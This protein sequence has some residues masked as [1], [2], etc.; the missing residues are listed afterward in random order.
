MAGPTIR[1]LGWAIP[2]N[3]K[4]EPRSFK[5][6]VLGTIACLTG[7]TMEWAMPETPI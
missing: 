6:T 2:F 5:G 3:A 1:M 7:W 4:A